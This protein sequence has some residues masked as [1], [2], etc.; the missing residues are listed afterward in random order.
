M[1]F[2]YKNSLLTSL[3]LVISLSVSIA[4]THQFKGQVTDQTEN[5]L[6]GATVLVTGSQKGTT[7]DATGHFLI[8]ISPTDVLT[9]RSIG[10]K[11]QQIKPGM[12]PELTIRLE[13]DARN[14]DQL[15][16][17]G[18]S[19][20]SQSQLSSSVSSVSAK[21]LEGSSTSN[22]FND[23]L[24]ATSPGINVSNQSGQPGASANIVIRGAGTLSSSTQPLYVVDGILND[25][26]NALPVNPND[27]A[28]ITVLKDGAATGI[29]GSRAANGVIVITTKKGRAGKTVVTYTGKYGFTDHLKGNIKLGSSQDVYNYQTEA[30]T[31]RWNDDL[32]LVNTQFVQANP[33]A[34][35]AQV[36][37]NLLANFYP[38]EN[39][40]TNLKDFLSG[41]VP[42]SRLKYNTDWLKLLMKRGYIN[43]HSISVSG[44][45]EKTTF[46]ASANYFKE[47]GTII[48]TANE[49]LDLRLN[50]SHSFSDRFKMD[51]RVNGGFGKMNK[52]PA[53]PG[54][55]G[56]LN[57]IYSSF[58][59]DHPYNTDGSLRRGDEGGSDPWLSDFRKNALYP[60][61]YNYD[62]VRSSDVNAD[63]VF[64]YHPLT[65]LKLSSSNRGSKSGNIEEIRVDS[66]T[67][68]AGSTGGYLTDA[69]TAS[70]QLITS[71]LATLTG[72]F[73]KHSLSGIVGAEFQ[74]VNNSNFISGGNLI[75][76]ET[77]ILNN[78][79]V[80]YITGGYK[81][82]TAFNSYFSQAD[83]NYDGKYFAVGSFRRDGSSVFGPS[84]K[85]G[86]FYSLGASW[87]LNKEKFLINSKTISLLKARF[88]Y[89]T[90][91]NSGLNSP[92][93]YF[94]G[95]SYSSGSLP[96]YFGS[97]APANIG[98]NNQPSAYPVKP[99]NNNLSWEVNKTINAGVDLGLFKRV[100]VNIDAY[101]RINSGL[102]QQVP[103]QATSGFTSNIINTG[104]V[105]N[106]GLELNLNSMNIQRKDFSWDMNFN[107]TFNRNKVISL[108][109]HNDVYQSANINYKQDLITSEGHDLYSFLL[110]NYR[111]VDPTTGNALFEQWQDN[112]GN[113]IS[114]AANN[115]K[116][117]K[118][119][120]ITTTTD[121]SKATLEYF[122]GFFPKF[123]A[124]FY[125]EFKYKNFGF[126]FLIYSVYGN[127]TYNWAARYYWGG[128]DGTIN[129]RGILLDGLSRWNKPGDHAQ[130]PK[131]EASGGLANYSSYNGF[132]NSRFL[133]N[134]SFIRLKNVTF[135]YDL[136]ESLLSHV[137]ISHAQ[138]FVKG[139]NLLTKSK[140]LG[141]DPESD[142]LQ[143]DVDQRYPSSR[144]IVF[145]IT[146]NF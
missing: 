73:G 124:G 55:T 113:V 33:N 8:D 138:V 116:V 126:S 132:N 48:P 106:R 44:G 1:L 75:P 4:Q 142:Y 31:N 23:L 129:T 84:H 76:D 27:I 34:T 28:S 86:N 2:F 87:L 56:V 61:K 96:G 7:T 102:L 42:A 91:G 118:P 64:E 109:G 17:V 92:S 108:A 145:G 39:N 53:Q 43:S 136:P 13:A 69:Y 6:P 97:G 115:G 50:L 135:S 12:R 5:P 78:A 65:W 139:D 40:A 21:R 107:I 111:G 105:Q 60:I 133:E 137:K 62:N 81:S 9:V 120:K 90:V 29:Y 141:F 45:S 11:T 54:Y 47:S 32:N 30:Y 22:D 104:K 140:F 88:S 38:Y 46:F 59:W 143:A 67:I 58:P 10:F 114:T 41:T 121:P 15:V 85:Y 51:I 128:Y 98:Y 101:K 80:P 89:A 3:L 125:N 19:S 103:F 144:K 122:G 119:A 14:L 127:K 146:L 24:Q 57:A 63:L 20:K 82:A 70:Y 79:A 83:Y 52:E 16:V 112:S 68:D 74:T 134:G 123:N 77:Y 49:T 66:R 100:T 37:Q 95:Y 25:A 26:S 71:N 18:Y 35:P 131:N 94:G 110:L 93:P 36:Q 117:V 130:E 72:I 99:T